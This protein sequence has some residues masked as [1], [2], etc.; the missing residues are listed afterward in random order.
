MFRNCFTLTSIL[1]MLGFLR[2]VTPA[3]AQTPHGGTPWPIPGLIQAEDFD[4]GGQ[5]IAY[6][7]TTSGNQGNQYRTNESVDIY[8][9][10]DGAGNTYEVSNIKAG[11][12]LKYTANVSVTGVY[13]LTLRGGAINNGTGGKVHLEVDGVD[14]TGPIDILNGPWN[15][16]STMYVSDI[17]LT[18]GVREIKLVM[19]QQDPTTGQVGRFN[20]LHLEQTSPIP[21]IE[22]VV[23][24][25]P[26]ASVFYVSPNGND[27]NPGSQNLPWKTI[28]KA[29]D[30][31]TAGQTVYIREGVYYER[32]VP[33]NSGSPGNY[34][35]YSNYPGETATLDATGINMPLLEGIASLN[36]VG[37][38][39]IT[40]L[41]FINAGVNVS[42][43]K[44]HMGVIAKNS[45]HLVIDHNYIGHTYSVGLSLTS[46]T[47][48]T[49]VANNE[50][51]DHY[52]DGEST[53]A[54]Y[55][56]AH[57]IEIRN[58]HVHN[59]NGEGINAVA[60]AHDITIHSNEVH[61]IGESGSCYPNGT[62]NPPVS[63]TGSGVGFYSDAWSEYT[64]NN[65]YYNNY[66]HHNGMGFGLSA[67]AGGLQENITMFN[68]ISVNNRLWGM[69]VTNFPWENFYGDYKPMNNIKLINNTIYGNDTASFG[70]PGIKIENDDATNIVVRNNITVKNSTNNLPLNQLSV[71]YPNNVLI[72]NNLIFGYASHP[73]TNA[74]EGVLPQFVDINSGDFHLLANS[75]AINAGT[76]TDAPGFDFDGMLRPFG[77]GYDIGAFEYASTITPTP[78][79]GVPSPTPGTLPTPPDMNNDGIVDIF[80]LNSLISQFAS[81]GYTAYQTILAAFGQVL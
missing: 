79:G 9:T 46:F 7:D 31:L 10:D 45:H 21:N 17:S 53:F 35:I 22:P 36:N 51:T 11:E 74:V 41:R 1:L 70:F 65:T 19:D 13:K 34:I 43:A 12:W 28:S 37:Y 80:D 38:I 24:P 75:P 50:V 69:I 14:V 81:Y 16:L 56:F 64:Y 23:I 27:S 76:A 5:G 30:T 25:S 32:L 39:R 18:A 59:A 42:Y 61:H 4:D 15:G 2:F 60:G 55:W 67:E 54:A 6:H 29:A 58:N 73:G 57:H 40:G 8:I 33:K 66:S 63:C 44:W 71:D 3:H 72:E 77:A 62:N 48:H 78:T 68:N 26:G 52:G 47:R 49:L 20:W